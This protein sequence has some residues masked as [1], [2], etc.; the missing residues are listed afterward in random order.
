[1][2]IIRE[3]KVTS[4]AEFPGGNNDVRD[5]SGHIVRHG[6]Y[7]LIHRQWPNLKEKKR[8]KEGGEG[9]ETGGREEKLSGLSS[10]LVS[11]IVDA[12]SCRVLCKR[13]LFHS[14]E[15]PLVDDRIFDV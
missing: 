2:S 10:G 14:G 15:Y 5:V 1:M 12:L 7:R 6:Q 4:A 13:V 8:G 11:P 3:L 9:R